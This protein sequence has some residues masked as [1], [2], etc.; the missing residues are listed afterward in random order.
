MKIRYAEDAGCPFGQFVIR[1]ETADERVILSKFQEGQSNKWKFWLHGMCYD[2]NLPGGPYSFNF[3]WIKKYPVQDWNRAEKPK[4][5][6]MDDRTKRIHS[7]LRQYGEKWDLAIVTNV[8]EC[9]RYLSD[10]DYAE[11][12]L[13]FD[14]GGE[15]F[16][17]P[18][19][20]GT[21]MDVV[22]YIEKFGWPTGKPK[23]IFRVHSSNVFAAFLMVKRLQ[24][25][26]LIA[27]WE[28]FVYDREEK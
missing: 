3:G 28:R 25:M 2:S 9:L 10:N 1:A 15:D 14:L 5:L 16:Q 12:H 6:F 18:W 4:M 11:V 21:G 27:V 24:D 26:D 22:R 20:V 19:G 8:K 7:A 23:P 13:D 17:D